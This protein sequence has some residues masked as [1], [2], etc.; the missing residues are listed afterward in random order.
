M[1]LHINVLLMEFDH[2]NG[3][4]KLEAKKEIDISQG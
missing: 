1:S 2:G 4:M 3:N